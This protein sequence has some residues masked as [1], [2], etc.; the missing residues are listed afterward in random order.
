MSQSESQEWERLTVRLVKSFGLA[1]EKMSQNESREWGRLT[2]RLIKSLG[3]A[4][5]THE[6]E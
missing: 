4:V 3:Q 1:V 2:V 6:L 5:D